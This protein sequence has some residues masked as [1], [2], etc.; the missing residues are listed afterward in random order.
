MSER[1][2]CVRYGIIMAGGSGERFWPVSRK[3]RPKQLLRLTSATQSMLEESVA[4][5]VPIIPPGRIYVV[6]GEH[7]VQ[8]IREA[9]IGIDDANVLAEPCKRNTAGCLLFAAAHL[10]AKNGGAAE[11]TSMAVVTADHQIGEPEL[12]R[13]SVTAALE[14]AEQDGLLV[15]HGIVPTRPDTGY[16]YI[17]SSGEGHIVKD[18]TI[19]RIAAFQ[20]KPNLETAKAYLSEGGYFWNSGMFFW[21]IDTFLAEMAVAQPEMALVTREIVAAMQ[22][23]DSP[24]VRSLFE[25]LP[26]IS[27]DYA[28]MEKTK[29][30]AVLRAEYPWDDVGA[31]PSLDRT[32]EADARGNVAHGD[33]VLVDCDNCIVYNDGGADAVAVGVVGLK[34]LVVVVSSDGVLVLPKDRA[35]DVRAIVAELKARNAPQL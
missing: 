31:W 19:F 3:M 14:Y 13:K 25:S 29:R 20:E 21:R 35:Q 23:G 1:A 9:G 33:P 4:R 24:A 18:L 12:F 10:V 34:D 26:D 11:G 2:G 5:L 16:G 6:T 28:L 8:P 27:I 15:T 7:L 32:R 17:Q 30:A 22:R